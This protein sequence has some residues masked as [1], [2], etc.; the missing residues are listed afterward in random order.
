MSIDFNCFAHL[1]LESAVDLREYIAV[2]N[3]DVVGDEVVADGLE[4]H[5]KADADEESALLW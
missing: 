5:I 4:W 2:T 3:E 1:I